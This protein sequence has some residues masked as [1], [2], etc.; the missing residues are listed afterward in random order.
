MKSLQRGCGLKQPVHFEFYGAA[1]SAPWARWAAE[2]IKGCERGWADCV[3]LRVFRE[4][5]IGVVVYHDY[6]PEAGVICMSAAGGDGWLTRPVLRAM[7]GYVFDDAGCQMAVLQTSEHNKIM[8]RI[9]LAFG[10]RE[11]VIPRLRGRNEAECLL[12]LTDDDWRASR[13]NRSI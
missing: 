4:D 6:N 12:T 1:N 3:A 13:F 10:Y 5:T 7:H 8:R 9:A 11:Y 2:R